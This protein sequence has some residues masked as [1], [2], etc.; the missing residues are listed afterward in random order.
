MTELSAPF[1]PD[2]VSPPGDTILDLIEERGWTQSELA[3]R[4][5]YTEKHISQL[6]NG[7]VPLTDEAALRLER[8]LGSNAGFWLAREA[9]YRE[10]CARLEAERAHAG[11][12]PWLDE[13]PI[14]ELMTSGAIPKSRN[15]AKHKPSLVDACL[16]FFGVASPDDWRAHYGGMQVA[17][18]RSRAEQSDVGAI[19][20]WLR[21]GEQ[22]A[23]KQDGP[24]YDKIRFE[25]ALKAIRRLTHETPGVFEPQLRQL[26]LEAGVAFVLVPAIP[27]AHVSGVAR[28]LSPTRPLIQLSLYGKTNDKFWFTFF[29]EAAHIVLHANSKEEKKSVFLDDPNAGHT[30]DPQE[31]EANQWAGDWLIPPEHAAVLSNV[32]SKE[33][34]RVFARQIGVHPGIVV[35]RMQHD[36]LIEPSWMNDLKVSFRFKEPSDS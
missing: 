4:L 13:L 12:V 27:R 21:L 8:V 1:A 18:R 24:K 15:D 11:W 3:R 31:H 32:R 17:F 19:S 6:I 20:S 26:L 10:H 25:K 23:E 16:R 28:W 2:W 29:H 36:R 5:G 34:V 9:K 14:K 35:G 22:Q 33:A 7:K 30:T